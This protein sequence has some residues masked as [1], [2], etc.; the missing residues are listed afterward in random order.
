M[1]AAAAGLITAA[2]LYA[3][4]NRFIFFGILHCI[5][6]SSVIGLAFMR[7]P[8]L[9]TAVIGLAFLF[10]APY[11][12]SPFFNQPALLWLGLSTAPVHS[13]DY[14][15]LFPWF[16]AVLLGIAV[17]KAAKGLGFFVWLAS[18]YRGENPIDLPF[19][20]AGRHSLVVYLIHQPILIGLVYLASLIIPAPAADPVASITYN[21]TR[22]CAQDNPENFCRRFCDCTVNELIKADLL[23]AVEASA[24]APDA[25]VLK[26]VNACTVSTIEKDGAE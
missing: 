8:A 23:D 25:D 18:A 14:V 4:P 26:I 16:G 9:L 7:L 24:E 17:A 11:L 20:F 12:A 21:C 15:P 13:N 19:A 10:A 6:V 2:T 1:V 3:M 22:T 5:A